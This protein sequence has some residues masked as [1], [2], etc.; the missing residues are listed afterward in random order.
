MNPSVSVFLNGRLLSADAAQV[1]ALDA[2]LQHGVGLFATMLGGVV[3]GGGGGGRSGGGGDLGGGDASRHAQPWVMLMDEHLEVL[4]R[5]C[6]ALGLSASVQ[7]GPLG[8]AVRAT[9]AHSGLERARVRVTLTAGSVNLL[10][11]AQSRGSSAT[12]ASNAN[13]AGTSAP[14]PAAPEATVL[15][16]AS[17]ATSYPRAMLERGVSVTFAQARANPF[18]PVEAHKTLSY[19]WRLREL[20]AAARQGAGEA[21][22]F[23]V[24]N[25]LSGGCVSNAFVVKDDE[26]FTPPAWGEGS[27]P[28][29]VDASGA[30]GRGAGGAG[31]AGGGGG[32]GDEG[33]EGEALPS[34]VRPGV[35]RE[36]VCN[37]LA[38]EG[39]V[40]QKR[41]LSIEDV[42]AADELWL[43]N[44]SWGVLP[45]SR[46][47]SRL[48][49]GGVG[50]GGGG[51]GGEPSCGELGRLLIQ[52]WERA[53]EMASAG[54]I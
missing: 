10:R 11:D 46:I 21:L 27:G 20:G 26:V 13:G 24:L 9:V 35:T 43:T 12:G 8:E 52:R 29:S 53:Q 54:L 42:L 30:R 36:W 32:G 7:V 47:E 39:V 16:V 14:G 1:S 38:G 40:V 23:S 18:N 31:G 25:Q 37:E 45:V 5:S 4:S 34:P 17:P 48:V 22:V 44:S 50:G 33:A 49:G 3:G 6:A 15:V 28:G 19:W 51:W 2:G 41:A